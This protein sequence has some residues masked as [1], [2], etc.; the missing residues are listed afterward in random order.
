MSMFCDRQLKRK[1]LDPDKRVFYSRGLILGED[2][3]T[4]DQTY[5]I[6]RDRIHSRALHGYGTVLGLHVHAGDDDPGRLVVQPG[7]AVDTRG[8]HIRVARPQCADLAD[9]L[10]RAETA[11]AIGREAGASPGDLTAYI[12]LRYRECRT[13]A[14][15]IA[16]GPCR[17]EDETRAPSRPLPPKRKRTKALN[18][19]DMSLP[20]RMVFCDGWPAG[21][22]RTTTRTG[23][24][25]RAAAPSSSV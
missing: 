15:P 23:R 7:V 13:D 4:Q 11:R 25:R 3:F 1:K 12:V 2:D 5:F 6:E 18:R 8:Q 20:P 19:P 10:A 24:S 16:S 21:S 22:A 17:F 9:W 14:V